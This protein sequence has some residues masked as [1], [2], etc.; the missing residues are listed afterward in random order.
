MCDSGQIFSGPG[1]IRQRPNGQ[2][3]FTL[4][5]ME[6]T[7]LDGVTQDISG[8][9]D[10]QAGQ[11]IP[12]R[13]LFRL[14]AIDA[15]G[16]EWTSN[17]ISPRERHSEEG[18]LCTGI[19]QEMGITANPPVTVKHDQLHIEIHEDIK[20]PANTPT[21]IRKTV[22]GRE[23]RSGSLSALEFRDGPYE[24]RFDRDGGILLIDVIANDQPIVDHFEM[25]LVEALQ[26]VTARPVHWTIMV[27]MTS[28]KW[29]TRIKSVHPNRTR[30]NLGPPIIAEYPSEAKWFVDIFSRYIT[31]VIRKQSGEKAHPISTQMRAICHASMGGIDAEALVLSIAIESILKYA[32]SAQYE[33]SPDEKSWIKKARDYFSTCEGPKP[34]N[35]R[36]TNWLSDLESQSAHG[37]LRKLVEIGVITPQQRKTWYEI[38]PKVAHGSALRCILP[39]ESL[40]KTN[41][42]LVMFYHLIFYIIGYTGKYTD[43]G[44]PDWPTR[45]YQIPTREQGDPA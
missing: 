37:K 30:A 3:E 2:L 18:T 12:E 20:I 9:N 32:P 8:A 33:L 26:F 27:K 24:Y 41:E 44:S 22:G 31:Y 4:Y 21:T 25:R 15:D 11:I 23:I 17:H 6:P 29:E 35:D 19:L 42:M 34:L 39:Q 1:V 7:S 36:A 45:D 5:A 13:L 28:T 43:H 40:D 10:I 38:R 16:R 14:S